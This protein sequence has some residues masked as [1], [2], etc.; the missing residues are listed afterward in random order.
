M[1]RETGFAIVCV[2]AL[3]VHFT[4]NKGI[5]TTGARD[6]VFVFFETTYYILV[7]LFFLFYFS[8]QIQ[9]IKFIT[10]LRFKAWDSRPPSVVLIVIERR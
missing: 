9:V 6:G 8:F 2:S 10:I 3:N 4:H 5:E 1:L 7:K